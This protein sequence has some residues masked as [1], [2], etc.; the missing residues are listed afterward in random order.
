MGTPL[1]AVELNQLLVSIHHKGNEVVLY[2]ILV[3]RLSALALARELFVLL[4]ECICVFQDCGSLSWSLSSCVSLELLEDA[5]RHELNC[6]DVVQ[7]GVNTGNNSTSVV[8]SP[9]L[10]HVEGYTRK[11]F[12]RPLVFILLLFKSLHVEDD[13]YDWLRK[14]GE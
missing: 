9:G 8:Q 1:G 11:I 4:L 5:S 6:V 12:L 3:G 13:A 10:F 7:G 14:E 2:L